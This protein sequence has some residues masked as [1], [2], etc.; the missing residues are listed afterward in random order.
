M[1]PAATR[2]SSDC[3]NIGESPL[4]ANVFRIDRFRTI[5]SELIFFQIGLST[6]I[7][8]IMRLK[9]RQKTGFGQSLHNFT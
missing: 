2:T 8:G 6:S 5:F 9:L 1:A 7:N 3:L 4:E